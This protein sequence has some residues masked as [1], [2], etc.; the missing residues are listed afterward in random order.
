MAAMR[1]FRR[2][3]TRESG[4]E[5]VEMAVVLPLLMLLI[6]GIVD[7]AF[8]LQSFEVVTNAAREGA[9]I[10][11]L[12]GYG[13]TDIQSRVSQYVSSAGLTGTPTTTVTPT[14]IT[15]AGGGAPFP[16]IQ[17]SVSYNYR[18]LFIG[19]VVSL[20]GRSFVTTKTFTATSV[21][22]VEVAGS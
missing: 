11:V 18:Y 3:H 4:A 22:R 9:R 17:V 14:T 12:P 13:T 6:A 5:L 2:R 21:M 10:G 1:L 20:L 7:F 8:L 19:P 15:P 16:A